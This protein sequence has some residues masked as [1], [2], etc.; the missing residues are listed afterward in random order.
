MQLLVQE[1]EESPE[2]I[3]SLSPLKVIVMFSLHA[4]F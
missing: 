2:L 3:F 4:L 1:E